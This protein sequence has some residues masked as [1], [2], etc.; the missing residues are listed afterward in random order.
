MNKKRAKIIIPVLLILFGVAYII[1]FSRDSSDVKVKIAEAKIGDIKA[2][3]STTGVVKSKQSRE[4]FGTQLKVNKINVE[5]GEAVQKG[6][7][8]LSYDVEDLRAAEKQAQIQYENALLQQK[9]IINQ[10]NQINNKIAELDNRI[11]EIENSANSGDLAMLP[12]LRQQ[13]E[14]I[15]PISEEKVKQVNNSVSLAKTSLDLAKSRLSGVEKGVI[16]DFNGTVTALNVTE[17]SI[18]NPAQPV[19]VLEDI[20][21]LKIIVS[22]GRYDAAK[23]KL[24]QEAVIR[25]GGNTIKGKVSFIN[26]VAKGVA[27]MSVAGGETTLSVEIDILNK[28]TALKI[29]FDVDVDILVSSVDN[30]LKIPAEAIISDKYDKTYVFV[31]E[32]G[33]AKEREV[34]IGVQSDTEIEVIRGL[35]KGDRVILN[36]GN[37]V[38]TGMKIEETV[39]DND[40]R[41]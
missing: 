29:N 37:V 13:R 41:S 8:I 12:V 30:V 2:Y 32:N 40:A 27:P 3:L 24:G 14:S 35:N 28:P 25:E 21:S 39:E 23:V 31:N 6:Q 22:L 33:I 26:P 20:D 9:E 16:A 18:G 19:A 1:L 10:R 11:K 17:G 34:K 15:Q 5:V 36:P 7:V 38:K 4:Y